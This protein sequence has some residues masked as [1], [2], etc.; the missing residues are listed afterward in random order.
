M[1]A[2]LKRK[3]EKRNRPLFVLTKVCSKIDR[4][5]RGAG[6]GTPSP[7]AVRQRLQIFLLSRPGRIRFALNHTARPLKKESN[8]YAS[9]PK[10][11]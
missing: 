7:I 4:D 2:L 3:T 9:H 5:R 10:G 11:G 6:G 1:L 8:E